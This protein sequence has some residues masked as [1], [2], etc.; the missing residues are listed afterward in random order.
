[1]K[2]ILAILLALTCALSLCACS[3]GYTYDEYSEAVEKAYERGY[4][5]GYYEGIETVSSTALE[6]A[7][8]DLYE[9]STAEYLGGTKVLLEDCFY[10]M[11]ENNLSIVPAIRELLREYFEDEDW[12]RRSDSEVIEIFLHLLDNGL[13]QAQYGIDYACELIQGELNKIY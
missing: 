6:E 4:E 11:E 12:Y 1:M 5:D 13:E 2:K 7:W 10:I 3:S 8:H 9:G